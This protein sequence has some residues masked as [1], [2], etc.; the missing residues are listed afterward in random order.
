MIKMTEQQTKL[1]GKGE[2][3]KTECKCCRMWLQRGWLPSCRLC[4]ALSQR[5]EQAER[6]KIKADVWEMSTRRA[7]CALEI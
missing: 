1:N 4:Q 3:Y 5:G 6:A 7:V 2:R